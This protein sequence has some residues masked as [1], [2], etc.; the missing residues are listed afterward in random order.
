VEAVTL[1]QPILRLRVVSRATER[2][3]R[4]LEGAM[5]PDDRFYA[6]RII[7]CDG[8]DELRGVLESRVMAGIRLDSELFCRSIFWPLRL[9]GIFLS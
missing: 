2:V 4:S 9:C 7:G 8:E 5:D 1:T 3:V 6:G